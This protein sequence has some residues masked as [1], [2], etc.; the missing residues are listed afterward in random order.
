MTII[1]APQCGQTKVGG[2][3]ATGAD[4]FRQDGRA[5]SESVADL[6]TL[7]AGVLRAE[8]ERPDTLQ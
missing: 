7:T 8:V 4:Q 1:V 3:V 5:G 2:A 6:L